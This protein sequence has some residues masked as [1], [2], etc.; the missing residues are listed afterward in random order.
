MTSTEHSYKRPSFA[1]SRQSSG[2]YHAFLS[3]LNYCSESAESKFTSRILLLPK[4]TEQLLWQGI[5]I[6]D[7]R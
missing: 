3:Y 6:V 4:S 1:W 7:L 2:I 5:V